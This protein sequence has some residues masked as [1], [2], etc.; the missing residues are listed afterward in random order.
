[1][2]DTQ[3]LQDARLTSS[4]TYH[5]A[6]LIRAQERGDEVA[7]ALGAQAARAYVE[8]EC[9]DLYDYVCDLLDRCGW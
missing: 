5:L 2:H 6:T 3:H 7:L 8:R 1:M 4:L 9:P